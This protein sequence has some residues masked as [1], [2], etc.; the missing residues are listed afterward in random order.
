MDAPV[1]L[2][3]IFG[4]DQL[5]QLINKTPATIFAD[6]CRAPHKIPPA[7]LP[8]GCK[9]PRWILADVLEWLRQH[10][11]PTPA[12]RAADAP[13]RG[14]G[15]PSKAERIAAAAAGLSVAEYRKQQ[16]GGAK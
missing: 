4:V 6:R 2:P 9:S 8:R 3:P 15:R 13:K 11:E 7:Y 1:A 10:P 14:P 5:S 16:Q 12:P